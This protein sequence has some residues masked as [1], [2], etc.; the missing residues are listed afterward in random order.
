MDIS[1]DV[2]LDRSGPPVAGSGAAGDPSLA[3]RALLAFA[4][5]VAALAL[6]SCDWVG[7]PSS[8]QSPREQTRTAPPEES[9]AVA[10]A[11]QRQLLP[12]AA[13]PGQLAAA[14]SQ[15]LSNDD[16]AA[17]FAD[18][19]AARAGM[20]AAGRVGGAVIHYQRPVDARSSGSAIAVVSSV[21]LYRT[22]DAAAAVLTAP[23][24]EGAAR[25]LGLPLHEI[26]LASLGEG[27]RAFRGMQFRDGVE[28]ATYLVHVRRA[29]L[30]HAVVVELPAGSDDGGQLAQ[31]LAQRQ[32][33][34]LVPRVLTELS[35]RAIPL[36]HGSD[37]GRLAMATVEE[38]RHGEV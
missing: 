14:A 16:A 20:E 33:A 6:L 28:I 5:A 7:K 15:N 1:S 25:N 36:A 30:L 12:L 27:S 22:A 29:N 3:G 24:L 10:A 35:A 38:A 19:V 17:F 32:A 23:T 37:A 13:V 11:L 9:P 31:R 2:R 4:L 8:S 26:P 18:P 34:P 21:A